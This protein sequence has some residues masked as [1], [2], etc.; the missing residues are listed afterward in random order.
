MMSLTVFSIEVLELVMSSGVEKENVGSW[1]SR[2]LTRMVAARQAMNWFAPSRERTRARWR[3][4]CRKDQICWRMEP[5][6]LWVRWS[7]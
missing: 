1:E 6:W 7:K 5:K 2:E 3:G 4:K